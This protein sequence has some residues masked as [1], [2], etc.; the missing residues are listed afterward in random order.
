MNRSRGRRSRLEKSVLF[1]PQLRVTHAHEQVVGVGDVA[2]NAE[3]LHQ[4]VELAMYIAAYL[5][6]LD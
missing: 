1:S 4:I 2:P 5:E 3:E 6:P